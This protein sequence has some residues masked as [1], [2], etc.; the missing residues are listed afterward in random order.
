MGLFS[1]IEKKSRVPNVAVPGPEPISRTLS[2]SF[3]K[4]SLGCRE[5]SFRGIWILYRF[6]G[7]KYSIY[8][9]LNP[10]SLRYAAGRV[11]RS[12]VRRVERRATLDAKFFNS[13]LDNLS[14]HV[15]VRC[16]GNPHIDDITGRCSP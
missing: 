11:S 16:I 14:D 13:L 1:F 6:D 2:L 8:A 5:S 10:S 15:I 12:L 4:I 7:R 3:L 9:L